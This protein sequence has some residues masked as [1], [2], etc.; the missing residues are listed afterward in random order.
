MLFGD[1]PVEQWPPDED[2]DA[3]PWSAFVEARR[4]PDRAV[5]LWLQVAHAESVEPRHVAQAWHFLRAAGVRP[6][7]EEAGRVL[8][9]VVEFGMKKGVD[10]L[11]VYADRSVRYYNHAGGGIE[12]EPAPPEHAEL[13]DALLEA[14]GGV[15]AATGP[16][17]EPRLGPP[18]RKSARMTF[19]TPG[20]LHFGQGPTKRLYDDPVGGLVLKGATLLLADITA[21]S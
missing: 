4:N 8:G 12:L 3:F 9:I 19:L 17:D 20:G 11:A 7:P 18:D 21:K 14:S 16:W 15:V 13:V 10:V 1:V 5:E 6:E 2:A